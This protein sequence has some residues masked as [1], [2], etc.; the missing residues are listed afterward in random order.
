MRGKTVSAELKAGIEDLASGKLPAVELVSGAVS[1]ISDIIRGPSASWDLSAFTEGSR[2]VHPTRGAG[3][4]SQ[5]DQHDLMGKP[6]TVKFDSGEVHHYSGDAESKLRV[7]SSSGASGISELSGLLP[8][9]RVVHPTRGAGVVSHIEHHNVRDKPITVKYASGEVHQYSIKSSSKLMVMKDV[10]PVVRDVLDRMNNPA[11]HEALDRLVVELHTKHNTMY[12]MLKR[13]DNNKDGVLNDREIRHGLAEMG[14]RLSD[15]ELDSVMRGFDKDGNG[16][17][18]FFE[19][20]T[21]LTQHRPSS[22]RRASVTSFVRQPSLVQAPITE[23]D[24]PVAASG[25]AQP[26]ELE[27]ENCFELPGA[28]SI[29]NGDDFGDVLGP[30]QTGNAGDPELLPQALQAVLA[31]Q[32]RVLGAAHSDTLA[33]ADAL[34]RS[35]NAGEAELLPQAL[36]A[37]LAAQQRILGAAHPDT[38]ATAD[39]FLSASQLLSV[40]RCPAEQPKTVGS[41]AAQPLPSNTQV[42]WSKGVG[43]VRWPP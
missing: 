36:Q 16:K 19:F 20:Y 2:V 21:V 41:G 27:L 3:Y 18:D 38:L 12:E 25:H 5:I 40:P 43:Q 17:V 8:G 15:T 7:T 26:A 22:N 31:A 39:A 24:A 28:E 11:M 1:D 9:T 13:L 34:L 32:R 42:A 10:E 4:V 29:A 6:V 30:P 35:R 33:T 14:V 23:D 37:V